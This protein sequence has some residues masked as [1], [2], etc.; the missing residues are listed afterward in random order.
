MRGLE[1]RG[2]GRVGDCGHAGRSAVVS[3]GGAACSYFAHFDIGYG[4][5]GDGYSVALA[6]GSG[7]DRQMLAARKRT[8]T[9]AVASGL[10]R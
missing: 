9:T 6:R 7:T 10:A 3:R 5:G 4:H 1:M 8:T 2:I